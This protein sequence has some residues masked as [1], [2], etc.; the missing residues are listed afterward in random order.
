MDT[1]GDTG[2]GRT[3]RHDRQ[4]PSCYICKS[5]NAKHPW[6]P[7]E[8]GRGQEGCFSAGS[9]GAGPSDLDLRLPG[10]RCCPKPSACGAAIQQ[11][12]K[13][14]PFPFLPVTWKGEGSKLQTSRRGK[15]KI[16][17]YC[18]TLAKRKRRRSANEDSLQRP[19]EPPQ[20]LG[21]REACLPRFGA[22]F[23]EISVSKLQGSAETAS[24]TPM[25]MSARTQWVSGDAPSSLRPKKRPCGSRGVTGRR[26]WQEGTH[27]AGERMVRFWQRGAR[28]ER[29]VTVG[30]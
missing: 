22:P 26:G 13:Q 19:S 2:V 7:E 6:V 27:E 23:P 3:P 28:S 14:V 15:L 25:L 9:E 30:F 29:E 16:K 21:S 10:R 5:A 20:P 17:A 1:D 12:G 18:K 8:L 24:V 4:R 11:P